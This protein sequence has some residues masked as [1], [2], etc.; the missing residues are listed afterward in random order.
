MTMTN[1]LTS[2]LQRYDVDSDGQQY[3][4]ALEAAIRWLQGE[5]AL[6]DADPDGSLSR[7]DRAMLDAGFWCERPDL[8]LG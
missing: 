6:E 3:V 8:R 5:V 4:A 1:F 7:L 2:L